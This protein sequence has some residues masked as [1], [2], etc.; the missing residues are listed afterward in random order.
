MT[1]GKLYK[2]KNNYWKWC[3]SEDKTKLLAYIGVKFSKGIPINKKDLFL[4]VEC[5]NYKYKFIYK[6]YIIETIRT[7]EDDWELNK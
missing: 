2:I 5:K 1:P 7:I 6:T 4:F 3:L